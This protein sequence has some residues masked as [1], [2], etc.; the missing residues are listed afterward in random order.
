[1]IECNHWFHKYGNVDNCND[2]D[3]QSLEWI[4]IMRI[5]QLEYIA[6]KNLNK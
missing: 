3:N 5:L 6:F 1:M 2:H 4:N